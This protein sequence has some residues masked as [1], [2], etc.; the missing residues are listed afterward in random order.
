NNPGGDGDGSEA[1]ALTSGANPVAVGD[2]SG[3]QNEKLRIRGTLWSGLELLCSP[4]YR[5]NLGYES[6]IVHDKFLREEGNWTLNQAYVPSIAN[7]NR[8]RYE[9]KLLENTLT[10][11]QAFGQHQINL[12]VG[13]TFQQEDYE[14]IWGTK[15][16]LLE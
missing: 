11:K 13:Q 7:E 9:N 14:Q 10:F 4:K 1:R 6:S 16:N 8:A 12:I 15:R 2:L 3:N 5:L